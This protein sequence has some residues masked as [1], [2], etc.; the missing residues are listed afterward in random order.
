MPAGIIGP[1]QRMKLDFSSSKTR[2]GSAKPSPRTPPAP[3]MLPRRALGVLDVNSPRQTPG[4]K[5]TGLRRPGTPLST[6]SSSWSRADRAS[7]AVG[8]GSVATDDEEEVF[9]GRVGGTERKKA[10]NIRGSRR[11][12]VLIPAHTSNEAAILPKRPEYAAIA[13]QTMFRA[14]RE[15]KRFVQ[16]RA[17]AVVIQQA[18]RAHSKRVRQMR[19]QEEQ[20][21]RLARDAKLQKLMQLKEK[22]RQLESKLRSASGHVAEPTAASMSS[23][24][25]TSTSPRPDRPAPPPLVRR[26][27]S[28]N[29][30]DLLRQPRAGDAGAVSVHASGAPSLSAIPSTQPSALVSAHS[31]SV[32]LSA[33]P[34]RLP[35]RNLAFPISSGTWSVA[36]ADLERDACKELERVTRLNTAR[37]STIGRVDKYS[38]TCGA[39]VPEE[40]LAPLRP[41]TLQWAPELTT[42]LPASQAP[43]TCPKSILRLRAPPTDAARETLV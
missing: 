26:G 31:E 7:P 22:R 24:A 41:S 35:R 30:F 11:R 3:H 20:Q 13:I 16:M 38:L 15:R 39:P 32:L 23:S 8:L 29:L 5:P 6:A 1:P 25:L 36:A 28:M 43:V 34:S 21:Q 18:W 42:D 14:N 17:A 19:E 27:C 2:E 40:T 10:A 37:N 12:T 4:K 33:P 9:F